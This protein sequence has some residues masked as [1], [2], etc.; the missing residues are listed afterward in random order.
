MTPAT[1]SATPVSTDAALETQL[2]WVQYRMQILLAIIV[3]LLG[4]AAYGYHYYVAHRDE[5]A[6]AALTGAKSVADFQ[7]IIAD[8]PAAPAAASAYLMLAET[9][10][11]EQKLVEANATLK[12][13]IEKNPKHELVATAKMAIA[14]N[15]DSL[16]KG[17]EALE[18]YRRLA[19]ENPRSFNAPF[20]LL[21]QVPLLKQKGQ[22]DD[23]RHVCETVLTQYSQSY[24]AQEASRLLRTLKP[25]AVTPPTAAPTPSASATP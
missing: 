20:A 21:S 2:F 16:G 14:G 6:A 8:Y 13:F 19:T 7:K 22:N 12:T 9:Q 1:R 23:A 18:M 17:D 4:G 11:K 5:T 25:A 3:L 10:R 24:A 15:L